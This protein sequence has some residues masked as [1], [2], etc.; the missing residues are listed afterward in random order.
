MNDI[1]KGIRT[2]FP[3]PLKKKYTK[4]RQILMTYILKLSIKGEVSVISYPK[5]GRT[6]LR[7]LIGKYICE[8][9][10]YP[11]RFALRVHLI[12]KYAGLNPTLFI[13]DKSANPDLKFNKLSK[14]KKKYKKKNV[15]FLA[16][17][18]KDPLVSHYFQTK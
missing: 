8:S 4:Y 10:N 5:C 17:G 11:E 2:S 12:T 9:F 13:H 6:W 16:R 18:I 14:N 15:I 3:P 7:L 1:I